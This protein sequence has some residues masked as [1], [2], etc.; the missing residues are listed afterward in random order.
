MR[1]LGRLGLALLGLVGGLLGVEGAVRLVDPAAPASVA[2][3]RGELT[4]PGEH[5]VRTAEYDVVVPV[6]AEGFVDR[7]WG[8]PRRPLVVVIGDSFVQAAQVRLE[9]GYGRQLERALGEGE[10]RSL[11]VPGAGTATALGLLDRHALR[12][13]PDLV[14]LGFLVANDVLNNHPLLEGKEDKPFYR[15]GPGGRLEPVDARGWDPPGGPLWRWSAAW[16]WV[17]GEWATRRAAARKLELGRGLPGELRVHDPHADPVWEEAWA[18]TGALL[19]EMA[20]RCRAA[21]TSLAVVLFPDG[22]QA[23]EAGRA[24]AVARW[25]EAAG[26]DFS[27]AQ[28]RARATAAA[29]APTLDLL[30]ALRA[31]DGPEPL[32]FA[33][34]GHWTARGHRVAAEATAGFVKECLAERRDGGS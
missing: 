34:D 16:R 27:R 9:E 13:K 15:L 4:T 10:V 3:L 21:G 30:P 22:V 19:A 12:W 31:A 17:A 32:Y 7:P 28:A 5:R 33:E 23:T 29:V 20:A 26:W 14:V 1:A 6:N 11:G 18:V 24:R 2:L 8:E 25:P